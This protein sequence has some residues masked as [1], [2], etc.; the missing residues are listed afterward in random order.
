MKKMNYRIAAAMALLVAAV[1]S[2]CFGFGGFSLGIFSVPVPVSPYFQGAYED[3]S[4]ENDRYNQ[5]VG[6]WR[7]LSR[8]VAPVGA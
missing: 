2:G 1:T 8:M 3:M 6:I 4:F 7:F 5:V